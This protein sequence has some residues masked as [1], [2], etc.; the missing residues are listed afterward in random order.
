VCGRNSHKW[1]PPS[2]PIP[3][4]TYPT[5][6]GQTQECVWVAL[7]EVKIC[8]L[9]LRARTMAVYA[10]QVK[11]R[12]CKSCQESLLP[13]CRQGRAEAHCTLAHPERI[14]PPPTTLAR[15]QKSRDSVT[16]AV[17][18]YGNFLARFWLGRGH[19]VWGGSELGG[20]VGMVA[21]QRPQP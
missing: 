8:S 21:A 1:A 11:A 4:N 14:T 16:G 18:S 5:T 19:K 13:P 12:A 9:T 6:V 17:R 3:L 20:S 15:S 2:M 10:V 7:S